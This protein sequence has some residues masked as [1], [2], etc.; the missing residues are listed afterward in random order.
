LKAVD[1]VTHRRGEP[2]ADYVVRCKTLAPARQVKPAVL[3]DNSRPDRS[4]LRVDRIA[5]D[6]ARLPRY[7]LSNRFLT[8][9]LSEHDYRSLMALHGELDREGATFAGAVP[10]RGPRKQTQRPGPHL[11]GDCN[12]AAAKQTNHEPAKHPN[13]KREAVPKSGTD[14]LSTIAA[15]GAFPIET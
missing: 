10:R 13:P 9:Q 1:Y 15:P 6:L 5:R 11:A 12:R 3:A 2:Y 14:R 4:I 8:D 7:L